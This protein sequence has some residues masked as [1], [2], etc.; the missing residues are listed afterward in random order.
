M[1][2]KKAGDGGSKTRFFHEL[3]LRQKAGAQKMRKRGRK[4][5]RGYYF[6]ARIQE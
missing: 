2:A 1:K 6:N 5:A 3:P 4:S